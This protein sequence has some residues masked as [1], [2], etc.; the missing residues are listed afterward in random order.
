MR[1]LL[2]VIALGVWSWA[3]ATT[4]LAQYPPGTIP[5]PQMYA[6]S[7]YGSS[8]QWP[9]DG[10]PAYE[11]PG[12][13][14]IPCDEYGAGPDRMI[15]ERLPNDRGGSY[16]DTPADRFLSSLLRA[17]YYRVEYLN[18]TF[19]EPGRVLLGSGV[20]G[21][22]DP[23]RDFEATISSNVGTVRVP[24][25]DR[26]RFNDTQGIRGTFGITTSA[27]DFEANYMAFQK[28]ESDFFEIIP[29]APILSPADQT[30]LATST[31]SN[32]ALGTNLF[33]YD[34][35]FRMT[36]TGRFTG[37][38]T[39]WV[40]ATPYVEGLAARPLI[41]F[42]YF[43]FQEQLNQR[44]VFDS[45]GGLLDGQGQPTQLVSE[46]DSGV[47]NRVFA[48]QLG[49]RLEYLSRW[50]TLGAEPKV[51][52]GLNSFDAD[53]TTFR[54]RSPG[55]PR[56]RSSESGNHFSPIFDL[57]LYARLHLRQNFTLSVGRQFLYASGI[58][59]PAENIFYND[60]G[61]GSPNAAI[62]VNPAFQPMFWHG[63]NFAAELRF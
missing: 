29:P 27:G 31:L 38:E 39:N 46:I 42:R 60:L 62:G 49:M 61:T 11:F 19:R 22:I 56:V 32:G 5:P 45:Q 43:Q 13:Q 44:G 14:R 35:S 51:G 37:A 3:T 63:W 57:S 53:V 17:T 10:I 26:L 30:L 2:A 58:S 1:G 50:V 48:P 4:A 40:W 9:E 20:A 12:Q 28:H 36:Q 52:F 16:E 6:P 59:R 55:D 24:T 41:G 8:S 25:T 21:Q 47:T 34:R 18:W 23:S 54:L 15:T 7:P 33:I